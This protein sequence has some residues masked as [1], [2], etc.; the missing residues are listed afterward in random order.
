MPLDFDNQTSVSF[1]SMAPP[2]LLPCHACVHG[3][4]DFRSE[5]GVWCGIESFRACKPYLPAPLGK[6]HYVPDKRN[7]KHLR[8]AKQDSVPREK[9][10]NE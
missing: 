1:S 8:V 5:Q 3:R 7:K 9:D 2:W 10:S 6:L 4:R